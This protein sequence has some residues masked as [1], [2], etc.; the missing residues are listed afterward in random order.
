[1]KKHKPLKQDAS[2]HGGRLQGQLKGRPMNSRKRITL[3]IRSTLGY[4]LWDQVRSEA[5][6]RS[7]KNQLTN[8]V[9]LEVRAQIWQ[10][11]TIGA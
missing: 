9:I 7:M 2:R 3:H 10:E 4:Q 1:M 5:A 11:L 6:V 8:K